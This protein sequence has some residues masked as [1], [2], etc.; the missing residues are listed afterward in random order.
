[1][2]KPRLLFVYNFQ[3]DGVVVVAV[4]ILIPPILL[5]EPAPE[6]IVS[7]VLELI[8]SDIVCVACSSDLFV[9]IIMRTPKNP[10]TMAS[11]NKNNIKNRPNLFIYQLILPINPKG[12][13]ANLYMLVS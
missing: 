2:L 6:S 13:T 7:P 10:P 11:K 5:I 1:M 8:D 12:C 3:F 9:S 4:G